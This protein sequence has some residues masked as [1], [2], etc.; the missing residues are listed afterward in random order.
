MYTTIS[1]DQEQPAHSYRLNRNYLI[2]FLGLKEFLMKSP[3]QGKTPRNT[4][5]DQ[6]RD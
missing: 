2:F 4:K 1:F 5:K 6:N 3:E